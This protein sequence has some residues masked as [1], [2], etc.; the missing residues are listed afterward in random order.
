MFD[1]S[2]QL[3]DQISE[4]GVMCGLFYAGPNRCRILLCADCYYVLNDL[5]H[6]TI[7]AHEIYSCVLAFMEALQDRFRKGVDCEQ[8]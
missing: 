5:T 4:L 7:Y 1:S 6:C 2:R 8:C 3:Y